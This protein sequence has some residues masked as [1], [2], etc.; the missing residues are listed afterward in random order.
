MLQCDEAHDFI[1]ATGESNSLEEF[2]KEAFAQV[3][4]D[5]RDHTVASEAL[6]RPTDISE[7]K[8]NAAKAQRLLGWKAEAHIK[9]AIGMMLKAELETHGRARQR[10]AKPRC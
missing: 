7:G 6:F 8:G 2:I 4:L 3:D 5:W 10:Q 1:T 9:D